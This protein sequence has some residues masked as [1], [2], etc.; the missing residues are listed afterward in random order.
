[1]DSIERTTHRIHTRAAF[2]EGAFAALMWSVAEIARKGL[3]ADHLLITLLVMAPA[4]AMSLAIFVAGR[5]ASTHPRRLIRRAA[6]VGRLPLLLLLVWGDDPWFLLVL[7]TIQALAAV[8]IVSSWNGVLRSNYS[9]ANRGRLFGRA[10]RWQMLAGAIAV[11]GSG[12]W[13]QQNSEAYRIF[14]PIAAL[15]GVWSCVIFSRVPR[16]EGKI[17]SPPAVRLSSARTLFRV[18]VHDRRFL[19]Y[20]IGFFFYGIGF[21]ALGTAKPFIT[22]DELG[23][24]WGVLLGAKAIPALAGIA[25]APT[26][27]RW[28]DQIGPARLGSIAFAGLVLY[29]IALALAVGPI[30]Y[31]LAEGVF[32]TAMT[33]VLILWNMGPV[34]FAREGEAMHYMS[35]HVALVGFR[36][37]IGHPI[38][39]LISKYAS[40]PRWVILFSVIAWIAGSLV[41]RRLGRKM[42]PRWIDPNPDRTDPHPA[43]TDPQPE[44]ETVD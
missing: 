4:V 44:A 8:L 33:G 2:F 9:D 3:G 27:G 17:A 6:I 15:L 36:G 14:L 1:M 42:G 41:M 31:C 22:V 37:L 7:V 29:G 12:L 10:S 32:G 13:A 40:D 23:L 39:G 43:G 20:E 38:G 26:F 25:L 21:M 28:M 35:V 16:R 34:A 30:T 19:Q 24:D 5:I 11:I 18:L